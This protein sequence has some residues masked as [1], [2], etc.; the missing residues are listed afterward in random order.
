ML[1]AAETNFRLHGFERTT[2]DDIAKQSGFTKRTIYNYFSSKEDLYFT[3]VLEGFQ[4]LFAAMESVVDS[5]KNGF[6]NVQAAIEAFYRFYEDHPDTF[7]LMNYL[8]HIRNDEKDSP[9]YDQLVRFKGAGLTNFMQIIENG[10]MD[11]SIQKEVDAE[12]F[13]YSLIFLLSG[14]FQELTSNG[15]TYAERYGLQQ[16]QFASYVYELLHSALMNKLQQPGN[17]N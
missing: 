15:N 17:P 5:S 13:T 8:G 14:F 1:R 2:M 11:G 4:N 12:M 16:K 10:K 6:E 7:L 9:I 3:V